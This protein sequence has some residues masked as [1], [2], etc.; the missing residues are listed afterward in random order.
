[1]LT[2]ETLAH[3][4][5]KT[6]RQSALKRYSDRDCDPFPLE[7]ARQL[8]ADFANQP[9]CRERYSL[10]SLNEGK[11]PANRRVVED[12]LVDWFATQSFEAEARRTQASDT[13]SMSQHFSWLPSLWRWSCQ[14]TSVKIREE[15]E[16][17]WQHP[18]QTREGALKIAAESPPLEVTEA[19]LTIIKRRVAVDAAETDKAARSAC[20]RCRPCRAGRSLFRCFDRALA[21]ACR[22]RDGPK[23]RPKSRGGDQGVGAQHEVG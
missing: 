3:W 23:S 4:D 19:A 12:F 14:R 18:V 21:E 22:S 7:T 17:L 11:Q 15:I 8:S 13:P 2:L 16:K 10:R 1:M 6:P 20:A 9:R 5:E